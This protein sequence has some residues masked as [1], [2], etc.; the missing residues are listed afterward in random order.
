MTMI[1]AKALDRKSGGAKWRDLQCA[2]RLSPILP[3]KRPR[4]NR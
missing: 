1:D 2:L 3:G 4:M